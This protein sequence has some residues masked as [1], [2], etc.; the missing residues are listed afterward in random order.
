VG[1]WNPAEKN[2][3]LLLLCYFETTGKVDY[4]VL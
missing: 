4:F 2:E 1:L 3:K